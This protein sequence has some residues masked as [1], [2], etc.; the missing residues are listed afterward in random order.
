M[1]GHMKLLT[2][3]TA[4]WWPNVKRAATRRRINFCSG[5]KSHQLMIQKGYFL[6]TID[7]NAVTSLFPATY[8]FEKKESPALGSERQREKW[9][10]CLHLPCRPEP[11]CE[12]PIART[13]GL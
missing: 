6:A 2:G 11:P 10:L 7:S 12:F 1:G 13:V 8:P 3:K 9:V 5:Q 4:P